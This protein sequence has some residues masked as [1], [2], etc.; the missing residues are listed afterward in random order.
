MAK[1][2]IH[3]KTGKVTKN[4]R[5]VGEAVALK[6]DKYEARKNKILNPRPKQKGVRLIVIEAYEKG[7]KTAAC[8]AIEM[9]N[10]RIGAQAYSEE[11]ANKWIEEYEQTR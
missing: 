2:D 10:E 9:A 7:G 8:K 4:R 1:S 3:G 5:S 11:I 6:Y